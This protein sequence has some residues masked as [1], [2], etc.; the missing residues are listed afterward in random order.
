MSGKLDQSLDE[1]LSTQRRGTRSR[2]GARRAVSG[3]AAAVVA[4]VGGVKKSVKPVKGAGK[5]VPTGPANVSGDSKVVVS[6]LPKDVTEGQIKEY[7]GKSIGPIKKVDI[8]YGPNGVSRGIANII[9]SRGDGANKALT[10]CNGLLVDGKPMK[11]EMVVDASRAPALPARKGLGERI[12]QPKS[13]PKSAATTKATTTS[14]KGTEVRGRGRRGR[15]G[16]GGKSGRPT[17]KTAEELDSEMAD[18]FGSGDAPATA[19]IENGAAVANGSAQP[20][21]NGDAMEDDIL[22]SSAW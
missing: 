10:Q 9:F 7:F 13:Q 11:I 17:K 22:V 2:R 19:T 3:R 21:T 18:Y 1:I 4:P 20:A 14:T 16:R 6:N 15:A 12:A 8:S 5:A